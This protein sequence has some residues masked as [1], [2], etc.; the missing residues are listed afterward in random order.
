M[1]IGAGKAKARRSVLIQNVLNSTR[2]K[3]GS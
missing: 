3:N 1:M 2:V